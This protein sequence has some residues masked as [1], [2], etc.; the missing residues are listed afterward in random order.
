MQQVKPAR[1]V[2]RASRPISMTEASA[3]SVS[4]QLDSMAPTA[5]WRLT[6][7]IATHVRTRAVTALV[8][9]RRL[10]A[11]ADRDGKVRLRL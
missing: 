8:L 10:C 11:S 1:T 5:S 4:A 9:E 6:G 3:F 7:V 2:V